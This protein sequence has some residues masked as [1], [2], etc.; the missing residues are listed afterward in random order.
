VEDHVADIK[1]FQKELRQGQDPEVKAFTQQTLTTLRQHLA[2]A[3]RLTGN[4]KK[5]D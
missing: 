1:A 5:A 3:N 4:Q 2:M